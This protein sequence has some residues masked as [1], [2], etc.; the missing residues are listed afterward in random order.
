M[1]YGA[2]GDAPRRSS[3]DFLQGLDQSLEAAVAL[4]KINHADECRK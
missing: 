4:E 2:F 3:D 1:L